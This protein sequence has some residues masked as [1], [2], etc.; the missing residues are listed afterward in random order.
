VRVTY[1]FAFACVFRY[2][3]TFG[4][5]FGGPFDD[6]ALISFERLIARQA[7]TAREDHMTDGSEGALAGR[8]VSMLRRQITHHT[9]SA[10]GLHSL[11]VLNGRQEHGLHDQG[12]YDKRSSGNQRGIAMGRNA[13]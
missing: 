11:S 6:L 12:R 7:R 5:P 9:Q 2:K 3:T 1:V 4:V 8:F 10:E 13:V